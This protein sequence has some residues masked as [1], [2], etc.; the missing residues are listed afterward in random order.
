[1]LGWVLPDDL[2][3]AEVLLAVPVVLLLLVLQVLEGTTYQG[4][5]HRFREHTFFTCRHLVSVYFAQG[6]GVRF[7]EKLFP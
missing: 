5:L 4:T 1:M 3:A 2:Q 6:L 7:T